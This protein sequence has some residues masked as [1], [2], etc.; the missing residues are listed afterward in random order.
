MSSHTTH[1]LV[2]AW[3]RDL[4]LLL[5]GI[6]PGERA[7]VL[8]GVHEHLDGSLPSDANDDDVRRVLADLGSPQSVADEA[9]AGRPVPAS[10]TLGNQP[11]VMARAWVPI[12]VGTLLGI[13]LVW[14]IFIVGSGLG[15]TT[16]STS[17][18][19]QA[20]STGEEVGPVQTQINYDANPISGIVFGL[21]T[22]P[23]LWV[24]A[25]AL[26][27]LSPLWTTRQKV[28][29]CLIAPVSALLVS[30]VPALGFA[31][32]HTEPGIY[33]GSWIGMALALGGGGWLLIRLCRSALATTRRGLMS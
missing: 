21:A 11:P 28:Y 6:D 5:H 31:V 16:T 17:G 9:Y 33:V 32:T 18:S 22:S 20:S 1:P 12:A 24:P 2:D 30:G 29:L 26:A 4:E 10:P 14:M 7:E 13:Y 23:L 19:V 15:Y 3:L 8:A 27:L 25:M